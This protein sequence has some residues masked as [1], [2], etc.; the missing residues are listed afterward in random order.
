MS[1]SVG[2]E[3]PTNH[4]LILSVMFCSLGLEELDT[5]LAQGN[6]YFDALFPKHKF[7]W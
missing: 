5:L 3:K 4:A 1:V 6:G 7:V 2:I